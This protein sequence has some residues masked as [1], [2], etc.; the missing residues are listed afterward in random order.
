MEI[1]EFIREDIGVGG[2]VKLLSTKLV[3][4]FDEVV[5]KPVLAGDFVT[6]REVVYALELVETFVEEAFARAA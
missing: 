5:A 3:L 6:H 2:K 1:V 4:H